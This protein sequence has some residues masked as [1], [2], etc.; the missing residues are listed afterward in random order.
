MLV[1]WCILGNALICAKV[2][3]RGLLSHALDTLPPPPPPLPNADIPANLNAPA[4]ERGL[5]FSENVSPQNKLSKR[6]WLLALQE[7]QREQASKL[8]QRMSIMFSASTEAISTKTNF[9]NHAQQA[10]QTELVRV[11]RQDAYLWQRTG[12]ADHSHWNP[13]FSQAPPVPALP[14][15]ST[16]GQDDV[17]WDNSTELENAVFDADLDKADGC[18]APSFIT[19]ELQ[20]ASQHYSWRHSASQHHSTTAGQVSSFEGLD[21]PAATEIPSS[22]AAA[23]LVEELVNLTLEA[24]LALREVQASCAACVHLANSVQA[25]LC[26]ITEKE[27]RTTPRR[28]SGDNSL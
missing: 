18:L 24:N 22:P 2:C 26:K 8:A 25:L 28:K 27:A 14:P 23:N 10:S 12:N 11:Q 3:A 20:S 15:S 4:M 16:S 6:I 13:A 17:P 7:D 1:I 5:K 9:V 19:V 21:K